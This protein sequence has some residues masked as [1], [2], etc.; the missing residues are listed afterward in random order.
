MAMEKKLTYLLLVGLC[1]VVGISQHADARNLK[2][3]KHH[4]DA[5][6]PESFL[7][8]SSGGI[9]GGGLGGAGGIGGDG[10]GGGLGGGIGS[11]YGGGI[12]GGIFKGIG[13]YGGIG[14]GLGGGG[15]GAIG[16]V[17]GFIGGMKHVDAN[18]KQP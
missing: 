2:E 7:G 11:G 4:E 1:L 9:G 6:K 3:A 13:G 5:K 12:G 16:G 15:I 17:G 14:V 18:N 10:L 8:D